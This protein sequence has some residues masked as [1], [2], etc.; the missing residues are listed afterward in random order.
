MRLRFLPLLAM[1]A[2]AC[3]NPSLRS[4]IQA[5]REPPVP[6]S[7]ESTS[8]PPAAPAYSAS[9]ASAWTDSVLRTLSIRQKAGQMVWPTVLGDF[10]PGDAPGLSLIHI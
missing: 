4:S 9:G 5:G 7:T 3:A 6:Q 8:R 1:V 2:P 10:V